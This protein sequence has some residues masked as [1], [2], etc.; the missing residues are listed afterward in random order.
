MFKEETLS[1]LCR[2]NDLALIPTFSVLHETEGRY[3]FSF[4]W[5]IDLNFRMELTWNLSGFH[6]WQ[7]D[8][9]MRCWD[10]ISLR[11]FVCLINLH[12]YSRSRTRPSR[13]LSI[14][15]YP[16]YFFFSLNDWSPLALQEQFSVSWKMDFLIP[17]PS[18][19]LM[20][21]LS[22]NWSTR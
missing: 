8:C 6:S 17:T 9:C 2:S 11:D 5:Q 7:G 4:V 3:W 19:R 16:Y 12:K 10:R 13:Q 22:R 15:L 14:S 21:R 20:R 1:S 18:R